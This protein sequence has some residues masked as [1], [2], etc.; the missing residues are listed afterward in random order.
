MDNLFSRCSL[1]SQALW[2]CYM[3]TMDKVGEP[4]DSDGV[5]EKLSRPAGS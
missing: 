3:S 1:G 4:Q 2:V 5:E